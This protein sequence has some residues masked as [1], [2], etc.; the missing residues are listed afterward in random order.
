MRS[1]FEFF[2]RDVFV[3]V[4]IFEKSKELINIE[5]ILK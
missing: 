1:R 5:L 3:Y 2:D 4:T